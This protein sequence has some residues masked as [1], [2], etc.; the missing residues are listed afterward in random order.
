MKQNLSWV[1]VL[2]WGSGVL[3]MEAISYA[4]DRWWGWAT[5]VF[6]VS[7]LMAVGAIVSACTAYRAFKRESVVITITGCSREDR[8][9][10]IGWWRSL[11]PLT[12]EDVRVMEAGLVRLREAGGTAPTP[13]AAAAGQA[14]AAPLK[15]NVE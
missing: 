12:E 4:T 6:G 10:W 2:A 9:R 1:V 3:L 5:W 15:E 7:V 13:G 8:L 14:D 11:L